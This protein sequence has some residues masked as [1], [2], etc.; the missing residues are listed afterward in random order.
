MAPPDVS[1]KIKPFIQEEWT[2]FTSGLPI[3][4]WALP[5]GML[6]QVVQSWQ[7][8]CEDSFFLQFFRIF[9]DS[10][11]KWGQLHQEKGSPQSSEYQFRYQN[12]I[13][14]YK[15]SDTN[16][17]WLTNI[18]NQIS[19]CFYMQ[20][21]F[22]VGPETPFKPN[23]HKREKHSRPIGALKTLRMITL[24]K[25]NWNESVKCSCSLTDCRIEL[26]RWVVYFLLFCFLSF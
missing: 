9:V 20:C 24:N 12:K 16:I 11:G 2:Q 4:R 10:R 18:W 23:C 1:Y 14:G 6:A 26:C 15:I 21:I 22:W 3:L 13:L 8:A 19:K 5:T 25:L 7:V 17:C